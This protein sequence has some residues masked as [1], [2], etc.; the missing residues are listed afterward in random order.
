MFHTQQRT[1]TLKLLGFTWYGNLK[2]LVYYFFLFCLN[3]IPH[4]VDVHVGGAHSELTD[5]FI[6]RISLKPH[7]TQEGDLSKLIVE[8]I[9]AINDP[10]SSQAVQNL[11]TVEAFQIVN[12]NVWCPQV[13]QELQ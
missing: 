3:P 5:M 1:L 7:G 9:S 10:H 4:V 13:I 12:E 6:K 8:H 11:G 2:L